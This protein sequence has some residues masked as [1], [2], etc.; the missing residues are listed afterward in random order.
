MPKAKPISL[1]PLTFDEALT[2]LLK[3]TPKPQK[4]SRKSSLDV[5]FCIC[6]TAYLSTHT[7]NISLTGCT[8]APVT[9]M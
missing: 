9:L 1:Y 5:L 7:V 4:K 8:F 6:K 2:M 3:A